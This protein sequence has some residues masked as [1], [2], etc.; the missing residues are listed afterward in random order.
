M[1]SYIVRI[2]CKNCKNSRYHQIEK[3]KKVSDYMGDTVCEICDCNLDGKYND[4]EEE[5]EEE[6]EE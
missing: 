3:G 1:D 6:K 2:V 4:E 5:S